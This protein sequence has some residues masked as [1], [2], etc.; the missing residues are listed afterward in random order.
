MPPSESRSGIAVGR[1]K[2]KQKV[3]IL[4]TLA[5]LLLA[6]VDCSSFHRHSGP[7]R[8]DQKLGESPP[9]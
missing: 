9:R 7:K 2:G 5:D 8:L 6:W 4:A 3:D 1:A